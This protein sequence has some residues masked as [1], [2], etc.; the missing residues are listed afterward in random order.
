MLATLFRP[1][2]RI[3][4]C[5]MAW[6]ACALLCVQWAGMQHRIDHTMLAYQISSPSV[7]ARADIQTSVQSDHAKDHLPEH[8]CALFDG[9]CLADSN[10]LPAI[11]LPLLPAQRILALWRAFASWDAP[12]LRHFSSRA[13]PFL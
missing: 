6:L 12:Q 3:R 10:T 7:E 1:T 11:V 4:P 8:S 13:P 5:F 9:I 2:T